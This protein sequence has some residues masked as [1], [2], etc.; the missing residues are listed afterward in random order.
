[1]AYFL[2]CIAAADYWGN[3]YNS[4]K[5]R[6]LK[7]ILAAISLF[8]AVFSAVLTLGREV[9]SRYQLYSPAQTALAAYIA[10]NTPADAVFLT[11]TRHNN[12]VS[13]LTGRTIVC[14]TDTFLYYHGLD[15]SLRQK[16]V[17][18][19]YEN[20][21]QSAALFEKHN[22]SYIVVSPYE[23]NS[24]QLAEETFRNHFEEIFSFEDFSGQTVLYRFS[25]D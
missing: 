14:G 22:V 18:Q 24:Y 1:M 15:T 19:M 13:S 5:N 10:E 17:Q 25:P 21:L 23:R 8:L 16:E 3:C 12:E 7:N 6:A 4:L 9:V 2:L 20:P 11:N